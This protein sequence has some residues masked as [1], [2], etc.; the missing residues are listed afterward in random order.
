MVNREE[1]NQTTYNYWDDNLLAEHGFFLTEDAAQRV[2]SRLNAGAIKFQRDFIEDYHSRKVLAYNKAKAENEVLVAAGLRE[3]GEEFIEP[4]IPD[5]TDEAI[6]Q[7]LDVR[8]SPIE[9][10]KAD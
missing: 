1:R 3:A 6:L 8:Y 5:T 4:Q 7:I 9:I 2:C 10:E